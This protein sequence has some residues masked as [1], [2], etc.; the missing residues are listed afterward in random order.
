M[1]KSDPDSEAHYR[2]GKAAEASDVA[3]ALLHYIAAAQSG[4]LLA[5]VAIGRLR[6]DP[7]LSISVHLPWLPSEQLAAWLAEAA[8]SGH[9]RAGLYLGRMHRHGWGVP[10]RPELAR[11]LFERVW[12]YKMADAAFEL[13][14]MA[15]AG[16][17]MP[18]DAAQA[19]VWY[20]ASGALGYFKTGLARA[21]E[22][23]GLRDAP[24][25]EA[26]DDTLAM[27]A[28]AP[29]PAEGPSRVDCLAAL[30]LMRWVYPDEVPVTLDEAL[31]VLEACSAND[32]ARAEMQWADL[33]D[34]LLR[35]ADMK[36]DPGWRCLGRLIECGMPMPE[37][38]VSCAAAY[39]RGHDAGDRYAT[40]L[41]SLC[42]L[43][44]IGAVPESSAGLSV[45]GPI[46]L[47]GLAGL[48]I[49][50]TPDSLFQPTAE[51][52][53]LYFDCADLLSVLRRDR[54]EV[55][56]GNEFRANVHAALVMACEGLGYP[57]GEG[58]L[59]ESDLIALAREIPLQDYE[60][61]QCG[62]MRRAQDAPPV[63]GKVA[64]G[65]PTL[66]CPDGHRLVEGG[67]MIIDPWL[68]ED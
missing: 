8:G 28:A 23:V 30:H 68:G 34:R 13:A 11:P 22:A 18:P 7:A 19:L 48:T 25:W 27:M 17:G 38:G 67:S 10:K 33:R 54:S 24:F 63:W 20:R 60:C 14:Q 32:L 4:H 12:G 21:R 55:F 9:A 57:L 29:F 49:R 44:S 47:E 61:P 37:G 58:A 50:L 1:A 46:E 65:T 45:A 43:E 5:M 26:M 59:R 56:G 52:V 64:N 36:P 40:A 6:T 42:S 66:A 2:Q 3:D 35:W 31:A 62:L 15:E 16:E 39:R 51:R 53:R 41:L